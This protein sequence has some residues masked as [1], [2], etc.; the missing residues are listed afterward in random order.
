MPDYIQES[1]AKFAD[2]GVGLESYT[3]LTAACKGANVLYVT[4]V[5][6]ERF[7]SDEAYDKVKV[8]RDGACVFIPFYIVLGRYLHFAS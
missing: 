2:A 1:C 5:Q 8:S 4:R 3:D 6:R 7:K